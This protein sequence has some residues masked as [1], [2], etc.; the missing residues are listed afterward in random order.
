MIPRG[1][2]NNYILNRI[3]DFP[4]MQN[5]VEQKKT[6]DMIILLEHH[7]PNHKYMLKFPII[8]HEDLCASKQRGEE[9]KKQ[10]LD[11]QKIEEEIRKKSNHENQNLLKTN[12]GTT[13]RI[14]DHKSCEKTNITINPKRQL[15]D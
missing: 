11:H 14:S 5:H 2:Q 6:D 3:Y 8:C 7:K 9:Q 13:Y 4:A 15:K 12:K 1:K 10:K